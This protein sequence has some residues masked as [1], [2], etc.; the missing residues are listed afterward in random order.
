MELADVR[1]GQ[2][3]APQ[4]DGLRLVLDGRHRHTSM[5]AGAP[6]SRSDTR[7]HFAADDCWRLERRPDLGRNR[8]AGWQLDRGRVAGIPAV[9][10]RDVR[11]CAVRTVLGISQDVLTTASP[12]YLRLP[13][14]S[15]RHYGL[16]PDSLR[17][18][19]AA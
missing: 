6:R 10:A 16:V 5:A 8:S 19:S 18:G 9:S 1:T 15:V 13:V 4:Y 14:V 11:I 17:C 2:A 7:P 3:R 12:P